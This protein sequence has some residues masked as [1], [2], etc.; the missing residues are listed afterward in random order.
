M[1]THV[2]V[3]DIHR[4]VV[5][6]QEGADGQHRSVSETSNPSTAE[7]SSPSRLK[8]GQLPEYCAIH[9]LTFA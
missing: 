5:T 3:S 2:M 1:N 4:N 9:G 8:S 6:G 7:S